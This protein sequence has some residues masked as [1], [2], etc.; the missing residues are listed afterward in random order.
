MSEG[1]PIV[2]VIFGWPA[3]LTSTLLALFGIATGR[4]RLVLAAALIACPFLFYLFLTPKMRWVT[5]LVA[6]LMFVAAG[7]TARGHRLAAIALV[8]PYFGVALFVAY[9]VISQHPG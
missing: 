1:V 8:A 3:V 6:T 9:L 2:A 5:P 7:A 4:S